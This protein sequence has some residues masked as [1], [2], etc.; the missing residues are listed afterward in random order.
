MGFA[1]AQPILRVGNICIAGSARTRE[2]SFAKS[3]TN[4][5]TAVDKRRV[6]SAALGIAAA[7]LASINSTQ[8]N[9]EP[10]W[11]F[12]LEE[13]TIADVHR[14]IRA[15]QITATE[16]V[17]LY[18]KRIEAYNGTCVKGEIDPATGLMLGEIWPI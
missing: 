1:A 13:S 12:H 9:A 15:K 2:Y 7:L 3:N 6:C 8:T 16:L 10:A 11:R 4:G 18:F 17:G 14:A 5:R